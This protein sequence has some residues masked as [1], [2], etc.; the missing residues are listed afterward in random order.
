[1]NQQAFGFIEVVGLVAAM[2]AADAAVKAAHI[3]LVGYELAKGGGMTVVKVRGDV[4]AVKAGVQAALTAAGKVNR[5]V[6]THVIPRPHSQMPCILLSA[7]TVGRTAAPKEWVQEVR[8]EAPPDL[9]P[10]AAEVVAIAEAAVEVPAI[11]AE[12]NPAEI[13]NLC[14]DPACPRKKGEPR[15][16]CLHYDQR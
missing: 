4:G 12:K 7:D 2:E 8:D 15:T 3:E 1:M 16:T 6:A 14:N 11:P 9:E 13:C 5:I 10:A